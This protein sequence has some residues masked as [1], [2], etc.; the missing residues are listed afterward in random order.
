MIKH[1][2]EIPTS[3]VIKDGDID[4]IVCKI[5]DTGSS[6]TPVLD[7]YK[8]VIYHGLGRDPIGCMVIYSDKICNVQVLSS[9]KNQ[10][11]VQFTAEN[12]SVNVRIW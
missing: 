1:A 12:A 7:R 2:T 9:D 8:H 10:I 6:I 4:A 3:E 11:T 5:A